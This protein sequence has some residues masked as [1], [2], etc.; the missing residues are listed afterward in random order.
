VGFLSTDFRTLHLLF[1]NFQIV[2]PSIFKVSH[3][4]FTMIDRLALSNWQVVVALALPHLLY[5]FIWYFPTTWMSWF[6]NKSVQVFE[7]LAWAL[8]GTLFNRLDSKFNVLK[9]YKRVGYCCN[10]WFSFKRSFL[11]PDCRRA[12]HV[13][14]ILV[15]PPL[16]RWSTVPGCHPSCSGAQYT[17]CWLWPSS[18]RQYI[19]SHRTCRSILWL[20]IRS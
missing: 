12:I 20:Q 19:P 3:S 15:P 17:S 7:S 10:F 16:P 6:K 18:Q 8:K 4:R 11:L 13:C 9:F 14:S 1:S 2:N 5:A